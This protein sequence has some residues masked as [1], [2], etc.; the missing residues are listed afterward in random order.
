MEVEYRQVVLARSHLRL[1]LGYLGQT[2]QHCNLIHEKESRRQEVF[3][4]AQGT[5]LEWR[6]KRDN[7]LAGGGGV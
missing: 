2:Y 6:T 1:E 3:A 7:S 5:D 4:T